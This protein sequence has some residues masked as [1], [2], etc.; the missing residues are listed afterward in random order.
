MKYIL[1]VYLILTLFSKAIA[2]NPGYL[3][4]HNTIQ[5]NVSSSP[6]ISGP[7]ASNGG[8]S[9]IYGDQPYR[10]EMNF[11]RGLSFTHA[12]KQNASWVIEYD[13]FKTGMIG[14]YIS[15]TGGG[16]SNSS[17]YDY[18]YCFHEISCRNISTGFQFFSYKNRAALAPYGM[19]CSFLFGVD[20]IE[21]RILDRKTRFDPNSDGTLNSFGLRQQVK[22]FTSKFE[23]GMN[24][25]IRNRILFNIALNT[26]VPYLVTSEEENVAYNPFNSNTIYS[27]VSEVNQRAYHYELGQRLFQHNILNAKVGLGFLLF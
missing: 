21:G 8:M 4:F 25:I 19:Y 18:H 27:S 15:T 26:R 12:I 11:I 14:N 1:S 20:F 23:L 24:Y 3:G 16:S 10:L 22:T 17:R 13:Q 5:V 7:T 9:N 6:S 2:Q